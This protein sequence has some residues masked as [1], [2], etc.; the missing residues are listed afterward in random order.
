M[1]DHLRG[2]PARA[3]ATG[4]RRH[5]PLGRVLPS[6]RA[7]TPDAGR[8]AP[9]AAPAAP[10]GSSSRPPWRTRTSS[11]RPSCGTGSAGAWNDR[12]DAAGRRRH[13]LARR[14]RARRAPWCSRPGSAWR[15]T[16]PD[17]RSPPGTAI[18]E[19]ELVPR[20]PRGGRADTGLRL[21][22][23][24]ASG[25][26]GW[27]CGTGSPA[28]RA[29][30]GEQGARGAGRGEPVPA[31]RRAAGPGPGRG[32]WSTRRTTS[33]CRALFRASPW[34]PPTPRW[35]GWT[36]ELGQRLAFAFH[37]EFGYLTALS[38]QRRHR[39]ARLGA[40]PP[41]RAWS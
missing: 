17:A 12:S 41:A 31:G 27:T 21:A 8:G 34:R 16:S 20:R 24:H 32:R 26:T 9:M 30:P 14:L 36:A 10:C 19:R 18:A 29:A 15:G 38:D 13:R 37:P 6:A 7:R 23:G 28:P 2:P 25:S 4:P 3:G 33:G 1:L 11:W 35:T 5:A 40:D 39:A 22:G